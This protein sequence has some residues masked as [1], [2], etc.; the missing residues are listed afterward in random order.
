MELCLT[1]NFQNTILAAEVA[2]LLEQLTCRQEVEG[3]RFL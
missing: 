3:L 2:D 1:T